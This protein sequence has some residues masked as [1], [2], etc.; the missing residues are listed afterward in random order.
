MSDR[1]AV[2]N[3]G[4]VEQIGSPREVYEH[5]ATGFVADFIGSLNAIELRVDALDDGLAVMR[6]GERAR[7]AVRA[8]DGTQTGSLLR[9][10][11]RPERIRIEPENGRPPEG[12]SRVDGIVAE[13]V[14]LGS[15]TQFHVDTPAGRIVANRITDEDAARLGAGRRV[16]LTWAP[17]HAS[18]LS[19]ERA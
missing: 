5:P 8:P 11:V 1:I 13:L 7:L 10:A 16:V 3:G 15:L 4:L 9:V 14:Y 17:E 18:V 19:A 12:G 6:L 2:M